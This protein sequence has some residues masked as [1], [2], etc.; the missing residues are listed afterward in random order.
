MYAETAILSCHRIYHDD[1]I[2][3]L[4][5]FSEKVRDIPFGWTIFV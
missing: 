5:P 4:Q 3:W 2:K 1:M